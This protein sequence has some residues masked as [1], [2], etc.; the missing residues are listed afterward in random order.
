M[1]TIN[2]ISPVFFSVNKIDLQ[3]QSEYTDNTPFVYY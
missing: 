2:T 1:K 3:Y